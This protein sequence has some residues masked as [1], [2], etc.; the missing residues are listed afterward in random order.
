[1]RAVENKNNDLKEKK[2]STS[3]KFLSNRENKVKRF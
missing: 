3:V 2:V 1:M